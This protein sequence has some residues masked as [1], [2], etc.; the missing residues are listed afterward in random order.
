MKQQRVRIKLMSC[1]R[2][3]PHVTVTRVQ[4]QLVQNQISGGRIEWRVHFGSH[5][6]TAAACL[7]LSTLRWPLQK[8][9]LMSCHNRLDT[10][11]EVWAECGAA[12]RSSGPIGRSSRPPPS[13]LAQRPRSSASTGWRR[14]GSACRHR[15]LPSQPSSPAAALSSSP[16][17]PHPPPPL[18]SLVP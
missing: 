10:G 7:T 11:W 12:I 5:P 15:P 3:S 6:A 8:P 9:S 16:P 18:S 14:S 1:W 2:S 13:S 17:S 4:Q